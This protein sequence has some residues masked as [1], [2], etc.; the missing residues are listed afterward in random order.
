MKLFN[1]YTANKKITGILVNKRT[2][3]KSKEK[4]STRPLTV[5][6]EE[7]TSLKRIISWDFGTIWV[8]IWTSL[9]STLFSP[10][11]SYGDIWNYLMTVCTLVFQNELLNKSNSLGWLED[12]L[13]YFTQMLRTI[14]AC[15]TRTQWRQAMVRILLF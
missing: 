14:S 9:S 10:L 8:Q 6:S 5:Q 2:A 7:V 11:T 15:G 4:S 13:S 1:T 12:W 3:S